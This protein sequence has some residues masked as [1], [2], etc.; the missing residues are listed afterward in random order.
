MVD[1]RA[2][3]TKSV[4]DHFLRSLSIRED[5]LGPNHVDIATTLKN[6][7]RIHVQRDEF[8]DALSNYEGTLRHKQL[9]RLD[10]CG[11]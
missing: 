2:E 1:V 11:G 3:A 9:R 7:G 5:C 4:M 10:S 6:I 8:D